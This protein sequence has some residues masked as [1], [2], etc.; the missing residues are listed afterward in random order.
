MCLMLCFYLS[1]IWWNVYAF[2]ILSMVHCGSAFEPGA[3]GLP[4]YCTQ[5]VCVPAVLGALAVWRPNNKKKPESRSDPDL[6]QKQ[7][8][9]LYQSHSMCDN[10]L[11]TCPHD[12]AARAQSPGFQWS[13]CGSVRRGRGGDRYSQRRS[14]GEGWGS[15]NPRSP[16]L[17]NDPGPLDSP[18]S[19]QQ[20]KATHTHIC[21]GQK[22]SQFWNCDISDTLWVF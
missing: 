20:N 9:V 14:W 17:R 13:S 6:K 3:S 16:D 11:W 4:Y 22:M 2:A 21:D 8:Q 5:P 18:I 15:G 1:F 7:K 19:G 12:G 10:E